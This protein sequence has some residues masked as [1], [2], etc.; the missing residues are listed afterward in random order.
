MYVYVYKSIKMVQVTIY[1]KMEIL[2]IVPTTASSTINNSE[3][4]KSL[5]C[6]QYNIKSP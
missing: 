2:K 5:K 6:A 1:D 4:D 3:N